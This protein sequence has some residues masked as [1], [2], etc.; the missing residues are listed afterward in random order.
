M[1]IYFLFFSRQLLL[2]GTVFVVL[3]FSFGLYPAN[4]DRHVNRYKI[5]LV[6]DELGGGR[7]DDGAL[8]P[9]EYDPID[10]VLR[11][12]SICREPAELCV[13]DEETFVKLQTALRDSIA[14]GIQEFVTVMLNGEPV[15]IVYSSDEA[16][17]PLNEAQQ[18]VK[19]EGVRSISFAF[20]TNLD[21][22]MLPF[23][24]SQFEKELSLD[25]LNLLE[26]NLAHYVDGKS[27]AC[28]HN[29]NGVYSFREV[30]QK[31]FRVYFSKMNREKNE[32]PAILIHSFGNKGSEGKQRKDITK[33]RKVEAKKAKKP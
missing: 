25:E 13:A 26:K 27:R 22:F 19:L 28:K 21:V 24:L 2:V 10:T 7:S 31:G 12:I 3:F 5:V 1:N 8:S 33:I 11:E 6:R 16:E 9:I 30:A 15:N 29:G 32:Q 23:A 14:D 20:L 17:I 4:A 18:K